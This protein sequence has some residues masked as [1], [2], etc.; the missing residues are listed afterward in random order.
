MSKLLVER[1]KIVKSKGL[2]DY[3]FFFYLLHNKLSWKTLIKPIIPFFF[4]I[5][6][7]NICRSKTIKGFEGLSP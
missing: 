2:L 3:Y 1:A 4:G 7:V 5:G 6:S